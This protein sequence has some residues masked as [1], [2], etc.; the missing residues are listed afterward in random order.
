MNLAP[1]LAETMA[2]WPL[3]LSIHNITPKVKGVLP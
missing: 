2:G 1:G 3:I